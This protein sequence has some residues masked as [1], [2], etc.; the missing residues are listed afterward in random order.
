VIDVMSLTISLTI[1][2]ASVLGAAAPPRPEHSPAAADERRESPVDVPVAVP[3]APP[4]AIGATRSSR[5]WTL[6]AGVGG[7]ASVNAEPSATA[8]ATLL[9]GADW[10]SFSL[11]LEGRADF[12]AGRDVSPGQVRT[13]LL[14]GSIVPCVR[15]GIVLG[16]ATFSVGTI[17]ATAES[18]A[19]AVER[20]GPWSAV[21]G[22]AGVEWA[23][24]FAASLR[25]RLQA[26]LLATL[27]RDAL[28]ID[29]RRVYTVGPWSADAGGAV[30][31]DFH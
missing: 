8:G 24:P 5:P 22:R 29:D 10:R 12:P 26:E 18:V 28:F 6:H 30:I 3:G 1:D 27:T 19:S 15:V 21:G 11:D 4:R 7:L 25:L 9:V 31:W 2:P 13:W 16:C 23:M 17:G 20:Y 14:A